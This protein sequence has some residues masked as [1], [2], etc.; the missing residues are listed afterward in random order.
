MATVEELVQQYQTDKALQEE[1]A[2]ITADGKITIS[3]FIAFAKKH[4]VKISL[5]DIPKY[6]E[7]AK[8]L[9]FI[10]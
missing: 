5:T 7:Q 1:V 4:D 9:G 3:E 10:K 8:Q 6:M 2:A